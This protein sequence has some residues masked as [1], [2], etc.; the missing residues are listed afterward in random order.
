MGLERCRKGEIESWTNQYEGTGNDNP[1]ERQSNIEA[2]KLCRLQNKKGK[3][4]KLGNELQ[5]TADELIWIQQHI[6]N[7]TQDAAAW[8]YCR[9]R[10]KIIE[11]LG[12][13]HSWDIHTGVT[14]GAGI[15]KKLEN[16]WRRWGELV[17]TSREMEGVS[18]IWPDQKGRADLITE[19]YGGLII[20][21]TSPQILRQLSVDMSIIENMIWEA[22]LNKY[23]II[24]LWKENDPFF[25]NSQ[26]LQQFTEIINPALSNPWSKYKEPTTMEKCPWKIAY[27]SPV[28]KID[29]LLDN[30]LGTGNF[31]INKKQFNMYEEDKDLEKENLEDTIWKC[32][33]CHNIGIRVNQ[34]YG[35]C[36]KKKCLAVCTEGTIQDITMGGEGYKNTET[37]WLDY[38]QLNKQLEPQPLTKTHRTFFTDGAGS[39]CNEGSQE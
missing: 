29:A 18:P 4:I 8:E 3:I 30:I 23:R 10:A 12:T 38:S 13:I 14:L 17:I 34:F 20:N 11:E 5:I 16:N 33:F 19:P 35:I 9:N 36:K 7:M 2:F 27:W 21:M 1:Q 6:K 39:I 31:R 26:I 15:C 25:G 22:Q 28:G 24:L 37:L 32:P